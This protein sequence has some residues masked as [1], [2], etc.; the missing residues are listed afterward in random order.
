MQLTVTPKE[1]PVMLKH[2][3]PLQKAV[4]AQKSP[5][6]FETALYR[7]MRHAR[8]WHLQMPAQPHHAPRVTFSAP[9]QPMIHFTDVG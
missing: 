8:H 5:I 9:P 4:S 3:K 1:G 6:S 2:A 7:R